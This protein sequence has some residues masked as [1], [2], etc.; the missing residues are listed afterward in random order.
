MDYYMDYY[1]GTTIGTHHVITV[2]AKQ[3]DSTRLK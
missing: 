2:K 3:T 1:I